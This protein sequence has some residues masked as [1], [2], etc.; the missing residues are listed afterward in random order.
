MVTKNAIIRLPDR[1]QHEKCKAAL[2]P[3]NCK[4]EFRKW[5]SSRCL[6]FACKIERQLANVFGKKLTSPYFP[7]LI[8]P[9]K[10]L[11]KSMPLCC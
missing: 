10:S 4:M 5:G 6:Q 8:P 2:S 3:M 7:Q 1:S 9:S 11:A